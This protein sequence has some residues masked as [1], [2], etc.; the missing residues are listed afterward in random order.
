MAAW[1]QSVYLLLVDMVRSMGLVD[2]LDMVIVAVLIYQI[3]RM[4]SQTRASQVLKGV[5]LLLLVNWVVEQVGF[6]VLGDV[7][8]YILSTGSILIVILFQ[9][10]IR[11]ALEQI[12]RGTLF[13]KL[14]HP[15]ERPEGA[16][17]WV[18][19]ELVATALHLSERK[20]GALIVIQGK[21]AL[22]DVTETGTPVDALISSQLLENIFEPNTPLHD[23]AV[24]LLGERVVAAA[25]FL[26][27]T[28]DTGIS[29]ELGTRHRAG[30]GV[31]EQ[32]D[33][34]SLIVS[35][36]SGVISLARGGRLQRYINEKTLREV[37][38]PIYGAGEGGPT[39][40]GRLFK[41]GKGHA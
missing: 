17:A 18:V 24:V 11:R 28:E 13:E 27:L 16:S 40:L 5:V 21:T 26:H 6:T 35:E 2:A 30:I 22:G 29:R 32:S 3:L 39:R 37:L 7:F 25:C 20:V 1:L 41:R 8:K 33:A 31:T 9:P 12:G 4:A 19:D 38:D 10:E 36:E 15:L 14:S 34:L 23:G